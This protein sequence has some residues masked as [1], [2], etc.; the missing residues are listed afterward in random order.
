MESNLADDWGSTL[1]ND[2]RSK[3]ADDWRSKVGKRRL[4]TFDLRFV[5]ELRP[6][7]T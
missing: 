2:W 7:T 6:S 3:L 5:R 1:T 4:S